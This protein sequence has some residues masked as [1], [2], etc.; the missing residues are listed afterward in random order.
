MIIGFNSKDNDLT[1]NPI[2][3]KQLTNFRSTSSDEATV[4]ITPLKLT[5]EKAIEMINEDELIE[6]TPKSIRMRKKIF[7]RT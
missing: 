2:K 7:K 1:V 6:I 4:L 3:T 5:L